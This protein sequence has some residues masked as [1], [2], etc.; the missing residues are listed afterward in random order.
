[1]EDMFGYAY[2]FNQPIGNWNTA[3]VRGKESLLYSEWAFNK[4]THIRTALD[5]NKQHPAM[6]YNINPAPTPTDV[7]M[8]TYSI[9]QTSSGGFVVCSCQC[10]SYFLYFVEC[11]SKSMFPGI[12]HLKFVYIQQLVVGL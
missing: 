1:M 3:K 12:G 9:C 5:I 7:I 4:S 11:F 6:S 8:H 10:Y 2:A